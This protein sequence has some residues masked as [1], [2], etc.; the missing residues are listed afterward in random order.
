MN[1]D[2]GL[3]RPLALRTSPIAELA[4]EKLRK[5]IIKFGAERGA[6]T[7]RL[8]QQR[9]RAR[10]S[11]RQRRAGILVPAFQRMPGLT[12]G[13]SGRRGMVVFGP[14]AIDAETCRHQEI[15]RAESELLT[16]IDSDAAADSSD[17]STWRLTSGAAAEAWMVGMASWQRQK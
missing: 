3:P 14:K 17:G 12:A 4:P 16:I 7:R 13:C 2:G 8:Q 15:E 5:R 9:R 1:G 10:T 11:S 6:V